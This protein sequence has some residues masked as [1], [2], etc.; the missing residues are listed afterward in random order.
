MNLQDKRDRHQFECVMKHIVV[1]IE[2]AGYSAYKQIKA[3]ILT[4][5]V[6]Y[7]TRRGRARHYIKRLDKSQ[8]KKYLKKIR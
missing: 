6:N 2:D 8:I 5:N 1:S 3:Y 7:I 4:S